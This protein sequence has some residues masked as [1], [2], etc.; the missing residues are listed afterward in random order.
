MPGATVVALAEDSSSSSPDVYDPSKPWLGSTLT[1]ADG[2]YSLLLPSQTQ[3]RLFVL[4]TGSGIAVGESV[5]LQTKRIE[6]IHAVLVGHFTADTTAA[7]LEITVEKDSGAF[8]IFTQLYK[9][10][11]FLKSFGFNLPQTAK[12]VWPADATQY[13][14]DTR[15][16]FIQDYSYDPDEFDDDIILHEFGHQVADLLSKDHSMGGAHTIYSYVDLRLSWSEGL[17]HYLSSAFRNDPTHV[18]STGSL[19]ADGTSN[20]TTWDIANPGTAAKTAENEWAVSNVLWQAQQ[21]SSFTD[22][23]NALIAFNQESDPATLDTF[24]DVFNQTKPNVDLT[25]AYESREMSYFQDSIHQKTATEP[26]TLANES[27]IQSVDNLTLFH[28]ND[29]D[30]FM[31]EVAQGFSYHFETG[32][33][34]NGALTQMKI[35][36]HD[37]GEKIG[38]VNIR[39]DNYRET[40]SYFFHKATKTRKL[41]VEV[42]RYN[43]ETRNYGLG[44]SNY[45]R[46]AGRYGGYTFALTRDNSA[47]PV[48]TTFIPG[49]RTYP[50]TGSDYTHYT[51]SS[52]GGCL[53]T[54]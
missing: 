49:N 43:S 46:T 26:Y 22:V 7:D 54:D 4:T 24:Y 18:D 11:V 52:K 21:N 40:S 27:G 15:C 12:T 9:A 28:Q 45:N 3:L 30:Y 16:T 1:A 13:N 32:N 37:S 20:A 19:N 44:L 51:V 50:S 53:L 2:T 31:T 17:A 35:Y 6:G 14:P 33:T 5:N 10:N 23:M 34:K 29:I 8:N 38:E 25:A 48:S 41:R 39:S 42:S 36:D 47:N